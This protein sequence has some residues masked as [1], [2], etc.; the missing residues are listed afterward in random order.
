[1]VLLKTVND[2]INLELVLTGERM[3]VKLRALAVK[4]LDQSH[5]I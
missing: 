3:R 1:M 5:D 2:P 4:K